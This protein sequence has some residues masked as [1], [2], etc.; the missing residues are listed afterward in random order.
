MNAK[1]CVNLLSRKLGRKVWFFGD[2]YSELDAIV[3]SYLAIIYKIT[4]PNNPLQ[5]HIK[6][7]QN[8]V[9]FIN[10]ITK[11]IFRNECYSSTKLTK[12]S[13]YTDNSLTSSERKFME[14]DL[15]TKIVAGVGA[16]LA[17]GAF[18]AWRGIYTQVSWPTLC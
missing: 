5:N 11:D 15:N 9:N 10:R 6:G 7:C 12:A 3:Y 16:V 4:L 17:M 13:T 1:K 2:I 18:A 8:L 14:T